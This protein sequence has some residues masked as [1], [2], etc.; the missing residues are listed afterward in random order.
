LGHNFAVVASLPLLN[1]V[2]KDIADKKAKSFA[3][4][5]SYLSGLATSWGLGGGALL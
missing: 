4:L 1:N 3:F 5:L 2:F